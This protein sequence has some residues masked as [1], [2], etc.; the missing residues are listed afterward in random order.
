VSNFFFAKLND[1]GS[2]GEPIKAEIVDLDL[3]TQ[4]VGDPTPI[5]SLTEG[6][7]LTFELDYKQTKDF[8]WNVILHLKRSTKQLVSKNILGR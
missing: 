8:V 1:D 3:T 7:E 2:Y 4:G 6:G 5:H